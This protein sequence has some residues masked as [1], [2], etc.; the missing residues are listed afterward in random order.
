MPSKQTYKVIGLMSGTSL[1]GIDLAYIEFHKGYQ[2]QADLGQCT[3]LPY[4]TK[5]R[6]I[7]AKLHHESMSVIRQTERDYS[8]LLG[9]HLNDFMQGHSLK[10]DVIASHG[11]TVWHQPEKGITLQI[12]DGHILQAMTKTPIVCD[13]RSQDVK[14]GGQGAPLVPIGDQLLFG[15]YTYCLN[16]GGFSNLS[17][18]KDGKRRAF[19]ICPANMALNFYAKKLGKEYDENGQIAR[20]GELIPR[21][22]DHLNALDYYQSKLPKSLGKEWFEAVFLTEIEKDNNAPKDVLRTLCEHIATQIAR[23]CPDGTTLVTGGG[24]HNSFLMELISQQSNSHFEIPEAKLV[25]YKE[26]LIFGL[27]GVLNLRGEVNCLASVTGASRDSVGGL[28]FH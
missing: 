14:L 4:S 3:T 7:L 8:Q 10:P 24:A 27:L 1:D 13:F 26:A 25:D 20:S 19:D 28:Q 5:W 23:A 17:F 15:E 6:Q 11:H 16:L 21:L 18:S 9:H 2:W 22:L 12:G